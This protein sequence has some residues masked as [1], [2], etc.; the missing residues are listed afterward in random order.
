[1]SDWPEISKAIDCLLSYVNEKRI[2]RKKK[3][4]KNNIYSNY[5]QR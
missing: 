3:G 2:S 4:E 5:K 1:M